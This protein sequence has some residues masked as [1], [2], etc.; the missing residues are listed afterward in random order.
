MEDYRFIEIWWLTLSSL[1][2]GCPKN[3]YKSGQASSDTEDNQLAEDSKKCWNF[4][5]YP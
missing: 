3:V 2:I 1:P 5:N 4:F